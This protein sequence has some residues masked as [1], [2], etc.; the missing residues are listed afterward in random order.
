MNQVGSATEQGA[1][2]E[3]VERPVALTVIVPVYNEVENLENLYN[4]LNSVLHAMGC[5][6]EMLFV[7][8]GSTDGSF[9][10]LRALHE[11]DPSVRV[12]RFVRNFGQQM[13]IS[14]G[15]N[16]ARGE[17]IV[18]LDAD[19]QVM[20]EEIP[21]LVEKLEEGY[22]IVYG[23]RQRR[24]DPL[25]RRIGSWCMSNLLYR[26]TGIDHPDSASGFI[27]LDRR[28]V[29]TIKLFNERSRYFNGLFAWLSYGRSA[30]VL[31]DHA[32]REAGK[33]KY[34]YAQLIRL[35]LNFVCNFSTLPLQF[36]MWIGGGLMAFGMLAGM[37]MLLLGLSR[38]FDA[39]LLAGLLIAVMTFFTGLQLFFLGIHGEYMSR[40]YIEVKGRPP[41]VVW[42]GLDHE[43]GEGK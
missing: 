38:A 19:L 22:D 25:L 1:A 42:E 39:P 9:A 27:A 28:F 23:V 10:G 3:I 37:G 6:H 13:A 15:F 4:R 30:C 16:Y 20:P 2:R 14:A 41:Y 17:I 40:I 8:D 12:V 32:P 26:I 11:R 36:A 35:T 7:D 33:S 21:K 34:N 24:K 5:S 29:D 43:P 31:V 18:L